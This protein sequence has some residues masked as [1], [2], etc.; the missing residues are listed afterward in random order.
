MRPPTAESQFS[1]LGA[2]GSLPRPMRIARFTSTV[3]L[4]SL[5]ISL[6]ATDPSAIAQTVE[7]AQDEAADARRRAEAASGL[8]DEAVEERERIETELA[9]AIARVNELSA[10]LSVV[11]A[12]LDTTTAQ[13]GFADA[14]MAT[15]QEDIE[16]HA[17][18][19]YM[20]IVSSPTVN[21]VSSKSVEDVLVVRSVVEDVVSEGRDAVDSLF[22]KRRDLQELQTSFLAQQS[23]FRALQD[24]VNAEVEALATL[25]EQADSAVADAIRAAQD[26]DAEYRAS[27]SAVDTAKAREEEARRQAQRTST[28]TTAPGSQSPGA[29]PDGYQWGPWTHPPLVERWRG[30]V[31]QFFPAERVE[32][33][34][35]IINCES[36]GDPDAVN[37]YS[38]ASGLFQFIP[39]T[40]A[41]TAPKAGYPGA[42]PF[43]PEANTA[44][45]AWLANRYSE[46]NLPYWMA[47]NCQRVLR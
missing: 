17:V 21:V 2:S 23:E 46:L 26:A 5:L 30:L 3:V 37:P 25:F 40:W 24:E 32:Q 33:A 43:D 15:I 42:S 36:N 8:V 31:Q 22:T 35:R 28:T 14:E 19:A 20:K 16:V 38:S 10:Q 1:Q 18:D 6:A 7:D 47:W 27:L 4:F 13:I 44:S 11:G 12:R 9:E 39:S 45:A 29:D 41:T 34:L